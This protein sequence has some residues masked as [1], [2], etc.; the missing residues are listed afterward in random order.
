MAKNVHTLNGNGW[1]EYDFEGT[2]K[3]EFVAA[4]LARV[5]N[6]GTAVQVSGIEQVIPFD[7]NLFEWD[8]QYINPLY[9][10]CNPYQDFDK[11]TEHYLR[12]EL[13]LDEM[14]SARYSLDQL[15]AAFDDLLSGKNAKGI[16]QF[17]H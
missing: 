13:L 4:R 2:A 3:P 14:I 11:I 5:R 7:M 1:A 15:P 9:G 16:I 10:Q 8:K 17:K 12:G 6:A